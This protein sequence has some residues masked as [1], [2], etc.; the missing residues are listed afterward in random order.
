MGFD[1]SV[2]V[3]LHCIGMAILR[4]PFLDILGTAT[5]SVGDGVEEDHELELYTKREI[6]G[7]WRE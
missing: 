5:R 4:A 7:V 3:H 2:A 1:R 6:E